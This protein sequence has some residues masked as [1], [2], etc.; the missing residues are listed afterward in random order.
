MKLP[1]ARTR[2]TEPREV[3]VV[4]K[5]WSFPP[6][7]SNWRRQRQRV[8]VCVSS[9][10][11]EGDVI[12]EWLLWRRRQ[13]PKQPEHHQRPRVCETEK[14]EEVCACVPLWNSVCVLDGRDTVCVW[15]Q[16][17]CKYFAVFHGITVVCLYWLPRQPCR[18]SHWRREGSSDVGRGREKDSGF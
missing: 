12:A 18:H 15:V 11:P 9:R 2:S 4:F 17:C 14:R 16:S 6:R 8:S 1:S 7:Y 5:K 13:G 3:C 10:T